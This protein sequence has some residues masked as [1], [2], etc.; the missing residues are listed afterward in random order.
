[1]RKLRDSWE[2]R[3][4]TWPLTR[5]YA[6]IYIVPVT[7]YT[8]YVC[9]ILLESIYFEWCLRYLDRLEWLW[10]YAKERYIMYY[11]YYGQRHRA[12]R[13]MG[14]CLCAQGHAK[15]VYCSIINTITI[16][17]IHLPKYF[18]KGRSRMYKNIQQVMLLSYSQQPA[19]FRL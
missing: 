1:M 5:Y 2:F 3:D 12:M 10:W 9:G 8:I 19:F 14:L 16:W 4:G 15:C 6:T 11:S 17:N 7:N 13:F 18:R